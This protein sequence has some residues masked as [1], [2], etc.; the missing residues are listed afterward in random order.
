[1]WPPMRGELMWWFRK[2]RIFSHILL[3]ILK[4]I[5]QAFKHD[6]YKFDI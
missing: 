2:E 3:R 4:N 1:M 5:I 6:N